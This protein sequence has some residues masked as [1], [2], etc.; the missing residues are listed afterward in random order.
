MPE[1]KKESFTFS[2]KIKSSKPAGSKSFAK[3]SSKV[4]RDGKPKQTLFERTRRD[5]P[6]F[7]A[8]L[9][10]LL[11]L[12]F[13]YKYSGQSGEDTLLTPGSEESQ[14]DPE[15]YGFDTAMIEDPDGQIAQLSGR[16]SFDLIQGWGNKEEDYG[17]RDDLDFD[18]S[19]SA[20][21][22]GEYEA[23]GR[24]DAERHS[25]TD[26]DE[27]ENITN[28]YKRRARAGTRAAFRRT[29]IGKL[30]PS[31][32]KR[33]GGSR[34]G[35]NPWGGSLKDAAK[36]VKA[37]GPRNAPKP[38]SLQPLRAGGPARS[39]FGQGGAAA[40]RKGLDNMG[41]ANAIEALRD[42]YVKPVG[43]VH[44]GGLDL[45]A[46]GRTGGNGKLDHNINI[47]KGQ[48]P[49]WWDMMKTR[50][51]KEWEAA[52][53]RKWNWIKFWDGLAQNILKG[54]VYCLAT[55]D[56][57]G[58]PD[59]FLGAYGVNSTVEATCCG[60]KKSKI[61]AIIKQQT[62]LEFSKEGC[63][64]YR[65]Y[66]GADKCPEGWKAASGG[67]N[68]GPIRQRLCCLG[69]C[70]NGYLSGE[71]ELAAA[72]G[73]NE[74]EEM[75]YLYRVIPSGQ[76]RKW[77]VYTYV[78]ARNYFPE[79]LK[80]R[81][82]NV[83]FPRGGNL[84]CVQADQN[85]GGTGFNHTGGTS[86]G[87]GYGSNANGEKN[88]RGTKVTAQKSAAMET[89]HSEREEI[90]QNTL[91]INPDLKAHSC[92]I[93]VQNSGTF[94]YEVFKNEIID[95][96]KEL[97]GG[98]PDKEALA[99]RA[100]QELD[101]VS[102]E[103]VAMK[104]NLAA[105]TGSSVHKL[106]DKLLPMLYWE[107][108]D[109]YIMHRGVTNRQNKRDNDIS[110]KKYRVEGQ[111]L[112]RGKMCY[113]EDW[114]FDCVSPD[115]P[116]AI[117][118]TRSAVYDEAEGKWKVDA[119][120]RPNPN[121]FAVSAE[122]VSTNGDITPL[123]QV[124]IKPVA[125]E[126]AS[127]LLY[128]LD[129]SG[130]QNNEEISGLEGNIVWTAVHNTG[131][132]KRT[133]KH[134]CPFGDDTIIPYIEPNECEEGAHDYERKLV[135]QCQ[136]MRVCHQG[137]W[138]PWVNNPEDRD[139]DPSKCKDGETQFE[140]KVA[141]KCQK[142]RTCVSGEWG[143]WINNPQD[144]DCQGRVT[145]RVTHFFDKVTKVPCEDD[146]V[147]GNV[148][149][150][151]SGC[152]KWKRCE[153]TVDNDLLLPL[154]NETKQ[155]LAAAKK[156]FDEANKG[157]GITLE[158]N[159][160]S[161]TIANLIDAIMIDP[162]NG[163]VPKNTVCLLGKSI[164]SNATDP[165]NANFDNLFGVFLAFIGYDAASFPSQRTHDCNGKII[166]DGRFLCKSI[167]YYWGGYVNS[168]E[169]INYERQV[170]SSNSPWRG[171]PLSALMREKLPKTGDLMKYSD[172]QNRKLFH[173]TY[174][175]LMKR[176]PCN[177]SGTMNRSDVIE[178]I[179]RLC[180]YGEHIKPEATKRY[181]CRKMARDEAYHQRN[182]D[183]P[184]PPCN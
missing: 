60:K 174:A 126:D 12:P 157:N 113:F 107:F 81:F 54:L 20:S 143:S 136:K 100:F 179:N 104:H 6:F 55:G 34:L 7:I 133:I 158:Y 130:L 137:K 166:R 117:L 65:T 173:Q 165:Y 29:Q 87:V 140:D 119:A 78:V 171:F 154:D 91:E 160:S 61:G 139:C 147:K 69:I 18:A 48:T 180:Q 95:Q 181:D 132:T 43:P 98:Q 92:V 167:K 28:I 118:R 93:Y 145:P 142:M 128:R 82:P 24:Y 152:L 9:V 182:T 72:N 75:P 114:M 71:L 85:H 35:I 14:F 123:K 17:D 116:S 3:S 52:F 50:M 42:S 2:D 15:R 109:A 155:Y 115:E 172:K 108:D 175:D 163:Q 63:D 156:K 96:F 74:C 39:T 153:L 8:A 162:G 135:G 57:G 53:E 23:E 30:D 21:A 112:I 56:S 101:L 32:L 76:A 111:D 97:L 141:G 134:T 146:I 49:W 122:F 40:A 176:T 184:N 99:Q 88:A 70:G 77:H 144:E 19:A 45:F 38:V 127:T 47:G 64:N 51:Q 84:L 124:G 183:C 90:R 168:R 177:Y 94:N 58:D 36:K 41:K 148:R 10:A 11:L 106:Y 86:A 105:G 150:G 62:G 37:S 161:V 129:M 80:N 138:G 102:V 16:S 22:S 31:N 170:S 26:I 13:L 25:R 68:M 44:T 159:E 67:T 110:K 73:G 120:N 33:A 89:N 27:E 1:E 164:G 83:N 79:S 131:T 103:S 125:T 169:R 46:D 59:H 151:E 4:G 121:R 178:Y 5:A 149:L 66:V